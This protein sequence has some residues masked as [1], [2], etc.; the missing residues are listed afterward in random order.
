MKFSR[1]RTIAAVA[2]LAAA[3]ATGWAARAAMARYYDGP[4]SDHF[5]GTHF[6]D[7]DGTPPKGIVDMIRWWTGP[8]KAQWPAWV[9]SPFADRPPARVT[10]TGWRISYV[11][12]ASILL[13][14]AGLNL[15]IDPVWSERVSP[16]SF[17]GPRRVNDPGV[18]F[19]ALP[20][21]DAVLVS[22]NHYDHLDV[23]TLA[24]LAADHRP[25]VVTPLGND[26]I[27]CA[28]DAAI[29]AE[30]YDWH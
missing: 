21:I 18:A 10:G 25:R 8:G 22:H 1:R 20:A 6:V 12:H 28:H 30:A 29:A 26:T 14:T 23:A 9:P 13:Q 15:L 2:G 5:N 16:F 27:M 17:A 7:P 11:G 19:E 4:V 24:S 3:G